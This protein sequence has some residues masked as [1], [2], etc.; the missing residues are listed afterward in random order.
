MLARG[1][2]LKQNVKDRRNA[3]SNQQLAQLLQ[4]GQINQRQAQTEYYNKQSRGQDLQNTQRAREMA[5]G[6]QN[7][8]KQT[9]GNDGNL[10]NVELNPQGGVVNST[11]MEGMGTAQPKALK[12]PPSLFSH[13]T[14][15]QQGNPSLVTPAN[16]VVAARVKN[17][18][19]KRPDPMAEMN[20][21]Q[22][23][24]KFQ[25]DQEKIREADVKYKK[26]QQLGE[27]AKSLASELL[28]HS[29][30]DSSIGTIQGSWLGQNMTVDSDSQNFINKHNQLKSILTAE[31][32]DM[33]T[34]V[35]SE[36]DIKILSDIAGGGLQLKGS[37]QAYRDELISM[38]GVLD[39]PLPA[40]SKDNGDGTFTMPNGLIVEKE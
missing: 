40:G 38:G 33:M 29:G 21:R 13:L 23:E 7:T 6:P 16:L 36:T 30:L 5:Q 15:E 26:G 10:Y 37:E 32:L 2:D 4:Q 35:L 1:F 24:Q 27:K 22:A 31:N 34:G 18:I 8:F 11:L 17:E 19:D 14:P 39:N 25:L 12:I 9:K 20:Q 28:N 3:D